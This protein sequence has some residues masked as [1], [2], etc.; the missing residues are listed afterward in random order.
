MACRNSSQQHFIAVFRAGASLP[1][2][3][4]TA[5][6][7]FVVAERRLSAPGAYTLR[8][9]NRSPC[10][11]AWKRTT[12]ADTASSNDAWI[13]GFHPD[14][15]WNAFVNKPVLYNMMEDGSA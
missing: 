8:K 3:K 15:C 1:E 14:P 13:D 7:S 9:K 2:R 5:P 6:I 4:K 12:C 10:V 11:P